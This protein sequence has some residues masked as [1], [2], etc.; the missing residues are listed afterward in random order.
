VTINPGYQAPKARQPTPRVACAARVRLGE[1]R[2]A[3][4]AA[5]GEGISRDPIGE[6][7]G[8]N[9]YGYVG[10]DPVNAVDP[11]GLAVLLLEH[12]VFLNGYHVWIDIRP[13]NPAMFQG[14][15]M[16]T[17][18]ARTTVSGE[19]SSDPT[20]PGS[21][22]ASRPNSDLNSNVDGRMTLMPP[23][24]ISDSL[25]ISE[26]LAIAGSYQNDSVRYPI[27]GEPRPFD[28]TYNSNSYIASI[29][30]LAGY[31]GTHLINSLSGWHP[32]ADKSIPSRYFENCH[33][34]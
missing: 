6:K 7:G 34:H 32:G 4:D 27:L 17:P 18:E 14:T 31:D 19:P 1:T 33:N 13:D 22:L 11:L 21:R 23:L 28:N 26:I 15:A 3:Y 5:Q 12:Q 10:N 9:L 29:L 25:L 2:F 24:G 8:I 30:N 16:N 20:W